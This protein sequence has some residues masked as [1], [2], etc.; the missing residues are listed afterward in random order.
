MMPKNK[1]PQSHGD[2]RQPPGGY[3]QGAVSFLR[4]LGA[5][6]AA[7]LGAWAVEARP[8]A[9]WAAWLH[10]Q[11]LAP[12]VF[13]RLHEA[14]VLMRLSADV[15][16]S[17]QGA[18]YAAAGINVVQRRETEAVIG[19][20]ADAGIETVLM[21]GTPLAYTVYD[22]PACRLKGDL[23]IWLPQTQ[24]LAAIAAL[25]PLN[26]APHDKSDRPAAFVALTGGEQQLFGQ[27]P[28]TGLVELQWPALRGEW[29]RRAAAVDHA[30][31]WARRV[32][33]S[34]EGRSTWGMAPED[35]LIHLCQHL[36]IM[37]G[38]GESA[39]RNLLDV[40]LVAARLAPDWGAV[41]ER[42]KAWRLATLLWTTLSLAVALWDAPVPAAALA[43]LQPGTA[44]RRAIATLDLANVVLEMRQ[45]AYSYRRFVIQMLLTDRP[46]DAWRLVWR[47]LFP[48]TEWLHA[49]YGVETPA[50]V[51]RERM[52]HP[53]RLL[54]SARA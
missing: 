51:W 39:L 54:T 15:Q 45:G 4:A 2:I 22:E 29:V 26:Y 53:L 24:M 33:V 28:G 41:V 35:L 23:D 52:L 34:I 27:N 5:P 31:I 13:H 25:R 36:A 42:A 18:Y 10:G 16:H 32:A 6:D 38:F 43:A 48:E 1:Q 11:S 9:E 47:A 7:A 3:P 50:A 30:A 14:G 46:R 40:H 21:K 20:L 12:F 44:R 19:A 49:R 8:D 17:L 37:H